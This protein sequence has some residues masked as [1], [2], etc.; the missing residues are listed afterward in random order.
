[1]KLYEK[2][3]FIQ[4]KL[5]VPKSQYNKFGNYNYRSCE[6]IVEAVKPL[7]AKNGL[8]MTISDELVMIG[9]RYYI[10]ATVTVIDIESGEKENVYGY[11]REAENKKGMDVSQITGATS[12]YARKYA[13]NGMFAIDDTKDSDATNQHGK[14]E[15]KPSQQKIDKQTVAAISSFAKRS[16]KAKGYIAQYMKQSGFQKW[17]D[18]YKLS[19]SEGKDILEEIKKVIK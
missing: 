6:D 8:T 19:E 15:K 5:N 2:L 10:K 3:S 12:S 13:L 17:N 16:E 1:M 4:S 11:A 7:L 9:D 14:G 18:L